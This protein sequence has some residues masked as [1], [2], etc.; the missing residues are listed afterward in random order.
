MDTNMSARSSTKA[1]SRAK[2]SRIERSTHSS[3][4]VLKLFEANDEI[5][6]YM[7]RIARSAIV[8]LSSSGKGGVHVACYER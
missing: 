5:D 7:L 3:P 1:A 8:F 6:F 2:R 4:R